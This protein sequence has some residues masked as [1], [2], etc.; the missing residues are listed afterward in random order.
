MRVTRTPSLPG[1]PR[2]RTRTWQPGAAPNLRRR[3]TMKPMGIYLAGYV[4]LLGGL[5]LALW[6][7][8]VL[9]SVGATW[10][11]IGLIAAVGLGIMV[12]V[13]KTSPRRTGG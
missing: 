9:R 11:V 2:N 12:A 5:L 7:T 10:T 13:A 1:R 8:G 6:K 4:L 3:V